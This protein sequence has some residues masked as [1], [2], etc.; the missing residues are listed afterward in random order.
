MNA[1]EITP[2]A[3]PRM[4]RIQ[5]V[6]GIFRTIFLIVAIFL[7]SC[8]GF[9][10][11]PLLTVP[12]IPKLTLLLSAGV[13]F[14]CAV[15]AWFCYKLFNLYSQGDLFTAPAVCYIR[16][17]GYTYFLMTVVSFFVQA[18]IAI[19]HQEIAFISKPDHVALSDLLM[20]FAI[21]AFPAFLIIFVAWIM[22]EGR[23][24][25]EEQELTV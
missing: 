10:I 9:V 23:K 2:K 12:N 21:T 20:K 18:V 3:N 11:I 1:N 25:Q 13:E 4:N 15:C 7:S 16:R 6:S 24:I 5:K 8:A 14:A 22:D 19:Q 17:I